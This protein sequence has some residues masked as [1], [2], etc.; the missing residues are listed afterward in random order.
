M[1]TLCQRD[2][3]YVRVEHQVIIEVN[4]GVI[5]NVLLTRPGQHKE[6]VDGAVY[7]ILERRMR[8]AHG[9]AVLSRATPPDL[10]LR[11]QSSLRRSVLPARGGLDPPGCRRIE[12]RR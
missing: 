3:R 10:E 4:E 5:Y 7:H 11:H 12:V 1:G 9:R 6:H 2:V 8:V